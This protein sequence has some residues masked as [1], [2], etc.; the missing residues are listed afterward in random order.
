MH[1]H[2]LVAKPKIVY[3]ILEQYYI[4]SIER[5]RE[6]ERQRQRQRDREKESVCLC[7]GVSE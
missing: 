1:Q 3:I 7:M 4:V 5:K 6:T 2:I